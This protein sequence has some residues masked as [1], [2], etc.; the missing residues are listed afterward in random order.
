MTASAMPLVESRQHGALTASASS[1]S[2][3]AHQ[4][5]TCLTQ[6]SFKYAELC[7]TLPDER[8]RSRRNMI[9][10]DTKL[11]E[12]TETVAT[13]TAAENRDWICSTKRGRCTGGVCVCALFIHAHTLEV[14][15]FS[16][17]VAIFH[18]GWKH[19]WA[20]DVDLRLPDTRRVTPGTRGKVIFHLLWHT[21]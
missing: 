6:K 9:Q 5:S 21:Q 2:Y 15:N 16:S 14:P 13:K 17:Q 10:A 8:T 7:W 20:L 11:N 3:G 1:C 18:Y 12:K 19:E 4:N